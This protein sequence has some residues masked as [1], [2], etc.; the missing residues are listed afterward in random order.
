MSRGDLDAASDLL[1]RVLASDPQHVEAHAL[2]SLCL[3]DLEQLGPAL[4]EAEAALTLDPE[5][6]MAH[7]A[8]GSVLLADRKFD[9]A[10]VHFETAIEL[11]PLNAYHHL[12]LA[13]LESLRGG[14]RRHILERAIELDPEDADILAALAEERLEVR[15]VDEARRFAIEALRNDPQCHDALLAMARLLMYEGNLDEAHATVASAL[16]EHPSREALNLLVQ[17]RTRRSRFLG[18]WMRWALMLSTLSPLRK[19]A[20]VGGMLLVTRLL[21]QLFTDLGWPT[22]S[23]AIHYM[24]MAFG[25]YCA[26]SQLFFDRMLAAELGSVELD[27]SY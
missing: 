20:L 9:R 5:E 27:D 16:R 7:S 11:S 17:I 8:M 19:A 2:L 23:S 10:A 1:R 4:A 25:A 26:L 12:R 3:C 15:D 6:P 13:H 14:A 18:L 22:L 21:M 24:W